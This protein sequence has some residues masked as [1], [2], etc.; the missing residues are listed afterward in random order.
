MEKSSRRS[1]R[2]QVLIMLCYDPRNP[3][4]MYATSEQRR[5]HVYTKSAAVLNLQFINRLIVGETWDKIDEGTY[6]QLI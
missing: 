6:L 1:V 4:V 5:R 2:I 3:D